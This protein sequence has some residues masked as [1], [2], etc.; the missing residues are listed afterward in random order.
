LGLHVGNIP[1]D[2]KLS[3]FY[4]GH[5]FEEYENGAWLDIDNSKVEAPTGTPALEMD[6]FVT[7][8]TKTAKSPWGID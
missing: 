5:S 2:G 8:E 6:Y 1:L 3:T 4:F 7:P